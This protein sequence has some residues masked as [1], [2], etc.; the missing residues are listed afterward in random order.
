MLSWCSFQ[1][2]IKIPW[3]NSRIK[4]YLYIDWYKVIKW[5]TFYNNRKNH[6]IEGRLWFCFW[7]KCLYLYIWILLIIE[8]FLKSQHEHLIQLS[9]FDK[10]NEFFKIL[11]F[12]FMCILR[13]HDKSPLFS[14]MKIL[15]IYLLK[16]K[17]YFQKQETES[18][19]YC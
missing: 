14:L 16:Y 4:Q 1:N 10:N 15:N 6:E 5:C 2:L 8:K 9:W 7:L 13:P 17:S 12:Y 19:A 18:I 3:N 11:F